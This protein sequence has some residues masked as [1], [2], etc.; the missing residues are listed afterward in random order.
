[1]RTDAGFV[2]RII[3]GR[4][5]ARSGFW[6]SMFFASRVAYRFA[7]KECGPAQLLDPDPHR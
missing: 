7:L 1:M 4:A 2:P 6:G 5:S 3:S